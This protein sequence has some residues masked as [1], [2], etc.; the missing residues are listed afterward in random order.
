MEEKGE[1]KE[2]RRTSEGARREGR[3]W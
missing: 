2:K 1:G 3:R